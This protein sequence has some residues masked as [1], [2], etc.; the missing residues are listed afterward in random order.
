M[1]LYLHKHARKRLFKQRVTSEALTL[2]LREISVLNEC[3]LVMK[4]ATMK[5]FFSNNRRKFF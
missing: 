2:T 3:L 1:L 4:N 5:T